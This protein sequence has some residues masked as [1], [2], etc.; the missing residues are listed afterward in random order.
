MSD[1]A[2]TQRL[3]W[4]LITAP[5]G[6][7]AALAQAQERGEDLR[8]ELLRTVRDDPEL[9]AVERLDVYANMY[10]YRLLDVLR[11]DFAAVAFVAGE[12]RFHNLVTDYLLRHFPQHHSLR[13]AGR[14]LPD[15]LAAH[16]QADLHPCL[17][18]L[19]RFEWA[20]TEAFDAEDAPAAT[21]D[22]LRAIPAEHWPALR[23]QAHPSLRLL[24]CE[25]NVREIWRRSGV[26]E[27][28]GSEQ[29][30]ATRC[31]VWRRELQVLHRDL[32]EAEWS[33]LQALTAAAP[34]EVL[35][36][37][38]AARMG[39]GQEDAASA[40]ASYLMRWTEDGLIRGG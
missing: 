8:A 1:L 25:W 34:F 22:E 20:L 5:E 7:E 33:G 9:S 19:A 3:L 31:C 23:L 40:A 6:V 10:F 16:R 36:A 32:G 27:R 2:R 35:C 39:G 12:A 4:K 38:I 11:D 37:E 29:H 30:V 15:F 24:A 13:W 18:D 28:P 26:G 14:F 21:A 17:G